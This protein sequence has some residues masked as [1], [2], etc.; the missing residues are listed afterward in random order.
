MEPTIE[1]VAKITAEF[2][3]VL[4]DIPD[5]AH[6]HSSFWDFRLVSNT[7]LLTAVCRPSRLNGP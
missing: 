4:L 1:P 3:P 6:T 7:A 5:I 2:A